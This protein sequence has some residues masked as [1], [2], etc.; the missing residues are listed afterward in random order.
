MIK[1]A[2]YFAGLTLA[3]ADMLRRGMSGKFRGR[4]E[5]MKIKTRF[6]EGCREKNHNP[7][8]SEEVWRQIESFAGYA[9]SKGHSASYAVESYQSLY[10]KAYY[11]KEFMV[12]VINNFGGFYR[13][14]F[15]VHEARMS[16]ATVHAP[17]INKSDYT[18]SISGNDVYLGF[19]HIGELERNVA[20][21]ILNERNLHGIFS[22]LEDFMK[23]VNI[24]VEQ[25]RILIRIGAFRF[26]GRTKKQLLW[27]IHTIIGAEKK[28]DVHAELFEPERK[29]FKLPVLHQHRLDDAL[30]E[31][32]ILGFP[33][34]SPFELIKGERSE[35]KG[36]M[37]SVRLRPLGTGCAEANDV[38]VV[39]NQLPSALADGKKVNTDY[40]ALPLALADSLPQYFNKEIAI[41]GYLV[42]TKSTRTKNGDYMFFGTFIDSEGYFFDTTHFPAIA[43]KYPLRGRGSYHIKGR[44]DNDFDYYTI[45]VSFIER[46]DE[47]VWED[48]V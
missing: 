25:L 20:D 34:C 17:H 21:D 9:F 7:K 42:T 18:T 47:I 45:N 26:T 43:A 28:T 6:F 4:E 44:V 31:I 14:E 29:N 46:L 40:H 13:T 10:L 33:L 16:G 35:V 15:Y 38:E 8:V 22:S 37:E 48:L 41:V 36:E 2:H 11:P 27:D 12:G 3:E 5:F 23:R 32:E 19:I 1:V 24:S 39:I 30:D